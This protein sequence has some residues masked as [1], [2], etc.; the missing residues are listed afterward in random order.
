[1]V[2]LTNLAKQVRDAV[3]V[4]FE[5]KRLERVTADLIPELQAN[6]KVAA[7]LDTEIEYLERE[8]GEATQSQQKAKAEMDKLREALRNKQDR[9]QF[10]GQAFTRRQVEDDLTRRL[11]RY[12]DGR[13]QL[14]AKQRILASRRQTLD[15]ATDKIRVC[16][17]QH[18]LLLQKAE[19]LQAELKLLELAQ[20]G[21][22]FE[23]DQSKL[24]EAKDLAVAVEKRIRTLHKLVD[25]QQRASD[26]IPVEADD[27]PVTE[28][29]DEYFTE[30]G[31]N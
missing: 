3:P 5:L 15:A 4:G 20:A 11:E 10:A 1:V 29:F 25:G 9:Y 13:V 23:F 26:A 24:R 30:A 12:E 17:Q 16:Q 27:R 19:S 18:D 28:K 6:R 14:E 21:G 8:L 31:R 22:S 2:A 7:Q